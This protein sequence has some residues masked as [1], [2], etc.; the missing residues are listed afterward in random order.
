MSFGTDIVKKVVT[1][2]I[3]NKEKQVHPFPLRRN[4]KKILTIHRNM[5]GG[6]NEKI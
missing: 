4:G 3:K 5:K 6:K 1:N 2:S